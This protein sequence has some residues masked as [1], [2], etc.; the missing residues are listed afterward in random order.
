MDTVLSSKEIIWKVAIYNVS[1]M[2]YDRAAHIYWSAGKKHKQMS[3]EAGESS[4]E[5]YIPSD[6]KANK[7]LMREAWV[8]D[9]GFWFPQISSQDALTVDTDAREASYSGEWHIEI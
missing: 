8:S 4:K 1:D 3:G 5:G 2:G 6:M 9:K 7:G